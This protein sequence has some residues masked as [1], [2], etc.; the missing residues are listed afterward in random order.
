MQ[1]YGSPPGPQGPGGPGGHPGAFNGGGL[2]NRMCA[3]ILNLLFDLG[4]WTEAHLKPFIHVL[5][6]HLLED[7]IHRGE[8]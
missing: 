2:V 8:E 1:G 7:Y 3:F 5:L 6:S 4:I